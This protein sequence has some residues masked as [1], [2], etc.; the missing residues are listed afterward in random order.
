VDA[1]EGQVGQVIQNIVLNADHAMPEGGPIIITAR[2]VLKPDSMHPQLTKGNY[3]EISVKDSGIGIPEKY[4]QKIFDP[5]FTTKE[6]GSGLG[7]ATSYS[8][9]RNHDGLI[10]VTSELGKG[11]TFSLY[12]PATRVEGEVRDF[13]AATPCVR[14]GKVLVMDD[15]NLVRSLAEELINA[16]GHE[17]ECAKD[18]M[19]AIEKFILARGSG[20]PFDIVIL[21][22]TV[23]SGMGGEQTIRELRE[24][25]P[26]GKAIVSSGYANSQAMAD[27]HSYGFKARLTKPYNLEGLRDTLNMLL[28][29]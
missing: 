16:L 6:K 25:D 4:L 5:Y 8:I 1:D 29:R 18:G 3:V 10:D 12:L 17:A 11:S 13:G 21:D 28:G 27:Y 9:V 19:E 22:L 14:K 2:N 24:I 15:D 26:G 20:K 23:K 7:L